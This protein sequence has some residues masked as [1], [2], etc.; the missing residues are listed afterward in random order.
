MSISDSMK[1]DPRKETDKLVDFISFWTEE[2]KRDGIVFGMSGG[3]DSAV[4]SY[5]AA[6]TGIDTKALIM[7]EKDTGKENTDDAINALESLGIGY[8]VTDITGYLN[9]LGVYE[10]FPPDKISLPDI[11]KKSVTLQSYRLYERHYG[12]SPFEASLTGLAGEPLKKYLAPYNAYYRVK[13]RLRALLLYLC[14][15]KEN[16]LIVGC[17]NKT[18]YSIGYYVK[19]G[20]DHAADIMPLMGLYKTQ[21]R[22]LGTYLDLPQKI[23]NKKPS[24]DILPGIYDEYAVGIG[25]DTLDKVLL[26]IE[27]GYKDKEIADELGIS[28]KTI[29]RIKRLVSSSEHMRHVYTP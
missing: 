14:S 16:R 19:F 6:R 26:G 9:S 11:M 20:C 8:Q 28:A 18:E 3:L 23:L 1:I 17:A 22:E 4:V 21:V 15:E 2:L 24:P 10:L 29:D 7:P 27:M 5:L 13:H 25:Y 12:K